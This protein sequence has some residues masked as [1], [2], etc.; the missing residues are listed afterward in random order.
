VPEDDSGSFLAGLFGRGLIYVAVTAL[1]ILTATVVSPILA[2]LLGPEQFGLLAS[3]I[4]LHQ[5]L[6]A[7]SRVGLDQTLVLVRAETGS[8]RGPRVLVTVGTGIAFV[9]TVFVALTI[10]V[11]SHELGF[12]DAHWLAAATALW[13][14]PVTFLQLS[15]ALLMAE[16]RLRAYALISIALSLG[17]QVVG[18]AFLVVGPERA[19]SVYAW[20]N[21]GGQLLAAATCLL[22]VRPKLPSRRD[23]RMVWGSLVLGLPI[24]L[25]TL[26]SFVLN[27]ADRLVIQRLMGPEQVGRYQI[28]YTIGV[29]AFTIFAYTGQAWAARFTE[30]R[31]EARRWQLLGQARDHLYELLAPTLLA[32]NLIAPLALRVFAP[33]SFH[34]RGLLD[35]VLLVS[36]S[37]VPTVALMGS[38]RALVTQR[39][40][41]PIALAAGLAAAVNL[42]LNLLLVPWIG[43][44]GAAL[45]TAIAFSLE[46][47][48]QR[49]AFRPFGAWP[50]TSPR[51][52]ALL[53][54]AM[55]VATVFAFADQSP[56]WIE[57]R[58]ALAVLCGG[59]FLL[60]FLRGRTAHRGGAREPRRRL[61][62][63]RR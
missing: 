38:T 1:P 42:V 50:R 2:H 35:I 46:A 55:A 36:L 32:V 29:E 9:L 3:A 52:V 43:L 13:T 56:H 41:K 39:R 59:W 11:W 25:S 21:L 18:L 10:R 7:V 48:V 28:A 54:G 51:I 19:A 26:C 15:L 23:G 63:R 60:A 27:S 53:L 47:V 33:H 16:D 24:M 44:A 57:L 17:W 5:V 14:V 49:L 22:L 61:A 20:G 34:P 45:A 62:L 37:G 31:D 40:T 4:A 12:G 6:M 30:I 58:T 8:N